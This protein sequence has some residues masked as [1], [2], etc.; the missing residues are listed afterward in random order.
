M[1]AIVASPGGPEAVAPSPG[2]SSSVEVEEGTFTV[3]AIPDSD[4]ID[5]ARTKRKV[6]NDM[7][8]NSENLTGEQLLAVV[9]QLKDI[10]L[11]IKQFQDAA[12]KSASCSA[13]ASSDS[14]PI[15]VVSQGAGGLVAKCN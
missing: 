13:T 9:A 2:E 5:Y 6:L 7:L 1:R 12:G 8:A 15:V 3:T 14:A 11:R 10:A 4:W